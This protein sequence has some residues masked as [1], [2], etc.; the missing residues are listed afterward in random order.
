[1]K[2]NCFFFSLEAAVHHS[3]CGV[4]CTSQSLSLMCVCA[5]VYCICEIA[6]VMKTELFDINEWSLFH[7]TVHSRN[8]NSSIKVYHYARI[9]LQ[10]SYEDFVW[11]ANAVKFKIEIPLHQALEAFFR[12]ILLFCSSLNEISSTMDYAFGVEHRFSQCCVELISHF[13]TLS[14]SNCCSFFIDPIKF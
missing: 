4:H 13:P 1:M 7:D 9:H 8:E 6:F 10:G 14:E 2:K 5:K 3:R 11:G 12:L